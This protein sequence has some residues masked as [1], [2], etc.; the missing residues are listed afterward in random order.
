M[1]KRIVD[2]IISLIGIQL[3]I[4][5]S[6]LIKIANIIS[7]DK[8]P[9][10][11]AQE[12]I[13]KDGKLFKM[14]KFRSMVMNSEDL[15]KKYLEENRDA[16]KEYKEYRKLQKDPRTTK[17]G[18]FI[19]RTSLDE[20]PQFI[21]VLRGEMSLVGPR[22]YMPKEKE[23]MGEYYQYIIKMKPGITGFW[24]THGRNNLKFKD[25]LKMDLEY[26]NNHN[27]FLDFKLLVKTIFVMIRLEG[28]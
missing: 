9:L 14:Y 21:N 23:T 13:G 1:I 10:F 8:G 19:R 25:R 11:Y 16:N 4:P 5:L 17:V 3:L 7:K 18:E 12:R 6:I 22:P 2:V 24:Q 28:N 15:L 27:L 20:F 26:Y